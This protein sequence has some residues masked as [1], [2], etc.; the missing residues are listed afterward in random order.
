MMSPPQCHEEIIDGEVRDTVLSTVCRYGNGATLHKQWVNNF[1]WRTMG[2]RRKVEI[3]SSFACHHFH[4]LWVSVRLCVNSVS[5]SLNTPWGD[6]NSVWNVRVWLVVWCEDKVILPCHSDDIDG[7]AYACATKAHLFPA[8]VRAER[9]PPSLANIPCYIP[10]GPTGL[11]MLLSPCGAMV[12]AAV[13][14]V[15]WWW[16]FKAAAAFLTRGAGDDRC[17]IFFSLDYKL[18]GAERRQSWNGERRME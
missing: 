12:T 17:H 4:V 2:A 10:V 9:L 15:Q 6:S 16:W 11:Q 13:V 7:R 14:D 1:V 18:S 5:V 3:I 8:L